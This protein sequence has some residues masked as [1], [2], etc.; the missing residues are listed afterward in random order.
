MFIYSN[1]AM[2]LDGKIATAQRTLFPLGTAED[3]HQMKV[4]RKGCDALLMGASTLRV[5]K[6]PCLIPNQ[7]GQPINIL[8][9][10][11]L[12]NISPSWR[13]FTDS[14]IQRILFVGPKTE[15][16]KLKKFSASSEVV[17]LK[18]QSAR[19]PIAKQITRY[20]EAKKIN[21][22]L[23][24]GG[25]EIMWNFVSQGLIDEFHVTLTPKI[26]GGSQSPT[27]VDGEGFKPAN[28]AHLTLRQCRIV[29]DELY[30]TYG[31]KNEN[32]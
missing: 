29:G 8:V 28:I 2:S 18:T 11:S 17:V 10:S 30:L 23:V 6:N 9:S 13:F 22:L 15:K 31:K 27:L 24:E 26:L 19:N 21:R 12:E 32:K 25:G 7:V 16:A 1:L 14:A 3:L 4:L 5:F 20:L